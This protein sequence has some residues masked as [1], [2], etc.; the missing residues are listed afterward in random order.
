[1]G[2]NSKREYLA[3]IR[4]RYRQATKKEK[5]ARPK[6]LLMNCLLDREAYEDT[7]KADVIESQ[8]TG[9]LSPGHARNRQQIVK[10]MYKHLMEMPR[11]ALLYVGCDPETVA[12]AA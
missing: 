5:A 10:S 8:R 7:I 11:T 3:A 1:M 9:V 12:V 6:T 4:V 2:G